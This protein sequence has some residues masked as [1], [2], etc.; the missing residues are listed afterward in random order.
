MWGADL[1]AAIEPYNLQFPTGHYAS[2]GVVGEHLH[3]SAVRSLFAAHVASVL[4]AAWFPHCLSI[5][6]SFAFLCAAWQRA[7]GH[8]LQHV[9]STMTSYM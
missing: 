4:Q 6:F 7:L 9:Q 2:V 8:T 5:A 3:H 1:I